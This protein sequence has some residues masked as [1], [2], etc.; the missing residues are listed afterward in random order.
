MASTNA[1][2]L[3][4]ALVTVLQ[5]A[6]GTV[7]V[8]YTYNGR[9]AEREYV[10]L[11]AASGPHQPMA[12]RNGARLVRQEDLTLTLHIE[13]RIP[14]GDPA[15]TDARAVAIGQL[16]EETVANDPSLGGTVT[17][18]LAAFVT[19]MDLTSGFVDDAVAASVL[20]YQ[21]SAQSKL[22]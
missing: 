1:P 15:T 20:T 14:G 4:A 22:A 12:F 13:V 18:L 17:G 3:K 16:V 19:H 21:I 5:A 10:Y 8:D 2:A 6:L 7:R 11:G 9:L